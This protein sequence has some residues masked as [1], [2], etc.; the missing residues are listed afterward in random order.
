MDMKI[1]LVVDDTCT[2]FED[3]LKGVFI[4]YECA[5]DYLNYHD[6]NWSIVQWRVD[7]CD[8]HLSEESK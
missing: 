7:M 6:R 5:V 3:K 2:S 8:D 1:Y 4:C